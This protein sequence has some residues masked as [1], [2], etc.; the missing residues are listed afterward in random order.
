MSRDELEHK[1]LLHPALRHDLTV[2]AS[3]LYS[4]PPQVRTAL[5]QHRYRKNLIALF[6][7]ILGELDSKPIEVEV[8]DL[9]TLLIQNTIYKAYRRELPQAVGDFQRTIEG[10]EHYIAL[11]FEEQV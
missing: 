5:I 7:R 9:E 8:A 10:D 1:L 4:L 6:P 3:A 11:S 2:I